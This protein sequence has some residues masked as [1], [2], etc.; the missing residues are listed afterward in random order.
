M[1]LCNITSVIVDL[2]QLEE[3][4]FDVE[5]AFSEIYEHYLIQVCSGMQLP[6]NQLPI[7]SNYDEENTGKIH[8]SCT[9][10]QSNV[11]YYC[12]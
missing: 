5:V 8:F 6:L 4:D 1:L 10:V 3:V 7:C 12:M 11:N 9:K 2:E